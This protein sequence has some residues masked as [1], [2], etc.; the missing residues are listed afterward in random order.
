MNPNP[1]YPTPIPSSGVFADG[2]G[3]PVVHPGFAPAGE[4]MFKYSHANREASAAV[5]VSSVP[6]PGPSSGA[7]WSGSFDPPLASR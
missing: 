4:G 5:G 1:P 2:Y 3:K 6:V 7:V